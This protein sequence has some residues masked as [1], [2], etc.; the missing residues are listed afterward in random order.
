[1]TEVFSTVISPSA[2]ATIELPADMSESRKESNYVGGGERGDG[3]FSIT[4]VAP[5]TETEDYVLLNTDTG[6]SDVP[7]GSE[8]LAVEAATTNLWYAVPRSAYGGGE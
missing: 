6:V 2:G 5:H 8:I 3:Q 1:M 7:S 4:V